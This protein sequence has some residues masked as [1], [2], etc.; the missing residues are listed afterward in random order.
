MAGK[1]RRPDREL[2]LIEIL[3][4]TFSFYS[5]RFAELVVPFVV[6]GLVTGILS[7]TTLPL[8]LLNYTIPPRPD[9]E[10]TERLFTSITRIITATL[11]IGLAAWVVTTIV[12]GMVVKYTSSLLEKG[13]ADYSAAFNETLSRLPSLLAAGF[14]TAVLVFLGL[15][16]FVVPGLIVAVIFSL[17]V[18]AIMIENLGAFESLG[19]SRRLVSNRWVKTFTLLLIVMVIVVLATLIVD[20]L[21]A[22]VMPSPTRAIFTNLAASLL[23]PI[24]VVAITL[25]YY[26]MVVREVSTP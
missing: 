8:F 12:S 5:S 18:P 7:A 3:A 6:A 9:I 1:I 22:L 25:L 24:Y 4:E 26:S 17:F 2:T 20:S 16:A 13:E 23:S 10:F 15:I 14:V 19:R 11:F 21:A